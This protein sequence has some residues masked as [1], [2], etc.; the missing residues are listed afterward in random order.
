VRK[1]VFRR[2]GDFFTVILEGRTI[3]LRDT[4]GLR[5][6]AAL[7][8]RPQTEVASEA[9]RR[10]ALE[11]TGQVTRRPRRDERSHERAHRTVTRAI[12]TT[13]KH[14]RT[15]DPDLAAYLKATIRRGYFCR[16]VP[17]PRDPIEWHE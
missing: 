7:L 5:Y 1:G 3:Q 16:Y 11:N 8:H 9:L 13:L 15:I 17:D 2:D 4:R 6:V 14:L 12:G 10:A